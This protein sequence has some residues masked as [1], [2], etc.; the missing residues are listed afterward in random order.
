MSVY[1]PVQRGALE[2]MLR[3]YPLGTLQGYQGIAAGMENTNYYL[4]TTYGEY[5]LTLYEHL[6]QQQLTFY[7]QLMQT[8]AASG[9]PVPAPIPQHTGPC[10]STLH[11]RPAALF[12]LL[13]GISVEM[14]NLAQCR[15][16]GDQLARL[17]LSTSTMQDL[18]ANPRAYAWW[19]TIAPQLLPALNEQ[20]R[21]LL[22]QE[23][24]FQSRYRLT[25]LP[26]GLI[27]ADLFR[28]NVL[29]IG[30]E[31]SGILDLYAACEGSWL[32]DLAVVVI[33][34]TTIQEPFPEPTL[35][36]AILDSYGQ[37][38]PL[39]ALERGAW[40]V[41]LR[42]AALRFWLSRL[43][44]AQKPRPG[45]L[46]QAKDPTVFAHRLSEFVHNEAQLRDLWPQR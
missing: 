7:L 26:R 27:H 15:A 30:E 24:E 34:W 31:L 14:P 6:D 22:Q 25:D 37:R 40:P 16:I 1:T 42:Q 3:S 13:G 35:C 45:T 43:L 17:H 11:D 12:P 2:A 44:E 33:D 46:T 38:R 19:K 39:T 10:L 21:Q 9:L 29:F 28:D 41:V 18:P 20:Q 32:Y 36:H 8:L 4:S 23:L 5:V